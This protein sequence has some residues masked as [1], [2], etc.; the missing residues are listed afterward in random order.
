VH[1][2]EVE[3]RGEGKTLAVLETAKDQHLGQLIQNHDQDRDADP[4]QPV[5]TCSL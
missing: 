5:G 1:A 2:H 3:K 4:Q